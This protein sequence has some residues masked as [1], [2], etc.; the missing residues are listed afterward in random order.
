MGVE[1]I[2]VGPS[3]SLFSVQGHKLCVSL[4]NRFG[5]RTYFSPKGVEEEDGLTFVVFGQH[6]GKRYIL[7]RF[8]LFF[9]VV[10]KKE[11]A[12]DSFL[13]C[14]Y[15]SCYLSRNSSNFHNAIFGALDPDSGA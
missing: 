5:L 11:F 8:H 2:E 3:G 12:T 4:P 1:F 15:R 10:E 6:I 9:V 13:F 14:E 7:L